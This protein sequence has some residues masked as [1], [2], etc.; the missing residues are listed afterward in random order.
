MIGR[1][2]DILLVFCVSTTEA[3]QETQDRCEV[4]K[5]E[6]MNL[7]FIKIFRQETPDFS[8]GGNARSYS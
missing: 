6:R 3:E 5:W 2:D 7:F 8:R 1:V 4:K